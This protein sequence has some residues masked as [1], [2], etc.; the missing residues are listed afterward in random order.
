VYGDP[1]DL[2]NLGPAY[3]ENLKNN[4]KAAYHRDTLQSYICDATS[5][6]ALFWILHGH[7]LIHQQYDF[8]YWKEANS[9]A[10]VHADEVFCGSGDALPA[11]FALPPPVAPAPISP[12]IPPKQVIDR[13]SLLVARGALFN[14]PI[15][16]PLWFRYK[17]SLLT[18]RFDQSWVELA[19]H[20][21][22]LQLEQRV[23][24]SLAASLRAK[25]REVH[26]QNESYEGHRAQ[27]AFVAGQPGASQT[28]KDAYLNL[29]AKEPNRIK[30]ENDF[31]V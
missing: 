13:F 29:Q 6:E 9:L 25:Q 11:A 26:Q 18:P 14:I 20:M 23:H 21:A 15:T 17:A 28:Q 8:T 16:D 1:P 12:A 3:L 27:A 2:Y 10:M 22:R 4:I 31:G 7:D 30:F 5:I 19:A 24:D